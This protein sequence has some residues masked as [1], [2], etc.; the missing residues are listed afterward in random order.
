V[1]L[2][3]AQW[4]TALIQLLPDRILRRFGLLSKMDPDT[5]M[6][7]TRGS[8]CRQ[9]SWSEQTSLRS[10]KLY[11][12]YRSYSMGS[13]YYATYLDGLRSEFT[14][15]HEDRTMVNNESYK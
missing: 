10:V 2:K 9:P 15:D 13:E 6:M 12:V 4:F 8:V 11:N 1:P 3:I 7:M 5:I 14:D